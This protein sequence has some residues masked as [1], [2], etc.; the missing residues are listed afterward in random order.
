MSLS[1]P[2]NNFAN[3][4]TLINAIGRPAKSGKTF[5]D[6]AMVA[7]GGADG[8]LKPNDGTAGDK[9]RGCV[10]AKQHPSIVTTGADGATLVDVRSG[11]FPFFIGTSA[12]VLAQ[13]DVGNVVYAIDDQTVGKTDGGTQRPRAG[14]LVMLETIGGVAMA[15]VAIGI[16]WAAAVGSDGAPAGSVDSLSA[17]GAASNDTSI[18]ELTV[19]GT[20]AY[21]IGAPLAPGQRKTITTIAVSASPVATLTSAGNT[22]GWT[23]I[24]GLG[25]L[26][27]TIKLV[28]NASLKWDIDGGLLVTVA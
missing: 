24:S 13:A 20:K 16:N 2:R 26:G 6:G 28:A 5:Y 9:I 27:A 11:I 23:T 12:D 3:K 18:T 25:A 19:A 8:W 7:V 17:S 15:W 4:A 22:N 21:T 10:E 1:A 14:E